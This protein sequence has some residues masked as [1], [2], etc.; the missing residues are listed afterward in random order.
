MSFGSY[1]KRYVNPIYYHYY[2]NNDY[3][4]IMII[5][6]IMMIIMMIIIIIIIIVNKWSHK[7]AEAVN[8]KLNTNCF[9][10]HSLIANGWQ[11][12]F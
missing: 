1:A 5:M 7:E 11:C 4:I 3:D 9:A 10:F 2:N 6:V 8:S 12:P